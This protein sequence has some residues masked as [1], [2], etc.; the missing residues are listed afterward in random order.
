MVK[1]KKK[2]RK[3]VKNTKKMNKKKTKNILL[4]KISCHLVT[5]FFYILDDFRRRKL[6]FL[7]LFFYKYLFMSLITPCLSTILHDS[8]PFS[9]F[10]HHSPCLAPFNM[11]LRHSPF[12]ATVLHVFLK[13]YNKWL[14]YFDS[15]VKFLIFKKIIKT[16]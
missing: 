5:L 14:L 8:P 12:I 1:S 9:I 7:K 10:I 3:I 15:K 11:F 6:I 2:V 16:R 4:T 13:K